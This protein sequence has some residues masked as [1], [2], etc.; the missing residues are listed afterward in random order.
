MFVIDYAMMHDMAHHLMAKG[1]PRFWNI[2][3]TQVP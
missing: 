2:T 1:G 3:G